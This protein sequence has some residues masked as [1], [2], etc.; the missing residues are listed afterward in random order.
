MSYVANNAAHE[1]PDPRSPE[2]LGGLIR[3]FPASQPLAIPKLRLLIYPR[4][5]LKESKTKQNK[6]KQNKTK[7]NKTKQNKTKEMKQ[8]MLYRR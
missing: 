7:Q 4:I 6:T 1:I 2:P 3:V 8:K 5:F